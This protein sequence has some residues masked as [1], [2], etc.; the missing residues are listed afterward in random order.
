LNIFVGTLDFRDK[1]QDARD[2]ILDLETLGLED[3]KIL[4]FLEERDK[5]QEKRF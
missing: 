1:K 3:F 2:K 4:G 5:K